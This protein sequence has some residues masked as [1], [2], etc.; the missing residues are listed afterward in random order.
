MKSVE[1]L[2]REGRGWP[3]PS[4]QDAIRQPVAAP[5][6]AIVAPTPEVGAALR[7]LAVTS[8]ATPAG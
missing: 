3:R 2:G 5:V 7:Y 8:A 6:A 1:V 4:R